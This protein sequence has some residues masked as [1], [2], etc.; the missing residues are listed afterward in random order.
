MAW[1]GALFGH[2]D[3]STAGLAGYRRLG[4][5]VLDLQPQA[6]SA[7]GG[8]AG[9][10]YYAARCLQLFADKLVEDAFADEAR[11]TP[12][13]QVTVAQ[14]EALYKQIPDLITAAK[15][16]V[17]VPGGPRDV[18]LPLIL[19]G[20]VA[21]SGGK[22]PIS[23]LRG[24]LRGVEAV[25]ELAEGEILSGAGNS[26][27]AKALLA[28]ATTDRDSASSLV[29]GLV[30]AELPVEST[31]RAED[32]LWAALAYFLGALQE[33][34]VPGILGD[35]DLDELIEGGSRA[36]ARAAEAGGNNLSRFERRMRELDARATTEVEREL[37]QR[38]WRDM[39]DHEAH[40]HHEHHEHHERH[41]HHEHHH[42]DEW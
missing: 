12:L 1:L 9:A 29:G 40:K 33:L 23:H 19:H 38:Q 26:A 37:M 28:E 36:T 8:R 14:A 16:E 7:D 42:H 24:M 18:Q 21:A 22:G 6:H 35:R 30:K 4:G 5:Q 11:P 25:G 15:Q 31:Q 39:S 13:P 32:L 27:R 34:A 41:E 10:Y 20:R 3:V 17:L 2:H